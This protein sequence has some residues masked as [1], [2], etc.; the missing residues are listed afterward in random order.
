MQ[1]IILKKSRILLK[2]GVPPAHPPEILITAQ[3]DNTPKIE[4]GSVAL[5][6]TS[7]PF[8]DI[9]QYAADNWLRCWFAGIDPAD[10]ELQCTKR[11]KPG[12]R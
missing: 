8:L 10:V 3:A 6:V 2:D 4:D 12:L 11:K 1:N 9:V 5:V 7:P